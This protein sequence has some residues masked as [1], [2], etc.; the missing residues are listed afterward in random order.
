MLNRIAALPGL[1]VLLHATAFAQSLTSISGTVT[2]LSGAVVPGAK[3]QLT[4]KT[5]NA[6]RETV[7][8]EAG[9]YQ[10]LQIAPG[11]YHLVAKREGFADIS[12][13]DLRLLVNTPATL[14]LSF[15]KVGSLNQVIEISATAVQLNT[16]D[17][18]LGNSFGTKPIVQL[19]LEGRRADR[20]LSLQAG[21]SYIG[22]SDAVN[23]GAQNATDRNGVVNGGRSDQS[24][25]TL[26]GVDINN[27]QTRDPFK[28]SLRVTLDSVQEFRVTTTNANADSSRGSGAQVVM[29]T[30]SG[31]NQFHGAAYEYL[32]NKAANANTFF[33]NAA[34]L[35]TPKLNRNIFGGRLGGKIVKDKL[36]F[37]ANYEGQRDRLEESVTRT[38]PR[39]S[40]RNGQVSYLNAESPG[41][42]VTLTQQQLLG[43]LPDA[44]QINQAALGVLQSYPQPNDFSLGDGFNTAGFRFNSPLARNYDTYV[45]K[46]DYVHSTN[47]RF[48]VR[49]QLQNDVENGAPQFPGRAPNFKDIDKSRGLAIG[50]DATLRSNLLSSTRYGYTRQIVVTEGIGTYAY[51]TF[52]GLS[53]PVGGTLPFIRKS[54]TQHLSQDFTW[55]K[56]NH[57]F[58]FGGSYREYL[59]DRVSFANSFFGMNINSS[60]MTGSGSILSA[61][62]A[63][64]ALPAAQRIAAGSRTAFN[65]GVAS[66]LGL[67]TQVNSRYNYLPHADGSVRAQAIGEGVPRKFKGEESEIYFQDTWRLTRNLTLTGGVRY[68]YWP[69]VYEANGVQTSPNIPLSEFFDRRVAAAEA[70]RSGLEA[71]GF[72]SF[73]L[74][75]RGGRPLYDNLHNWSPRMSLAYS[76]D[77]ANGLSRLLFGG[78]GKSVVRVGWG[79]YYDVFG[80]GLVRASDASALG[81]STNLPNSSGRLTLAETPRFTG[82][83]NV[84][85]QLV[86]PAPAASFPVEQPR[87]AFQIT[88]GLDDRLKAPYIM[89]WNVSATREVKEGLT[90][91]GAYVA[92]EGRRT[93]TSEDMATPLNIRDPQSGTTYFEAAQ[94]LTRLVASNTPT[95]QVPRIA[96]WENLFPGAAGGGLSAT[97]QVFNTFR[98]NYPDATAALESMDRFQDPSVSRL[99]RFA[100]YHPQ[101]SYLRALRSVGFSSYHSMQWTVRKQWRS[102]DQMD[103]NWTWSHSFD[104][105]SVTE[106][107]A[108]TTDGLRGVSINPYNRKQMRAESDFDQR[109]ALN[110]NGIYGLPFG[111]GRAIANSA[112]GLVQQLVGGWQFGGI[113]RWSTGLPIS[114]GHNRTWPT[115]YN[116]TG[117]ATTNGT[118]ADGTNKNGASPVGTANSGPNVFQNPVAARSAFGFTLPGEIG[119]R[120][121]VRGDGLFNID[122][123][124]NKKFDLP[125][126]G[127]GI[128]FRWEVFNVTNSVRFDVRGANINLGQPGAFGRYST[129][130]VPS[131]VMQFGLRYDF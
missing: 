63:A 21:I 49:G 107:N 80:A 125:W 130:L 102:G 8:D 95:A 23:G 31:T 27:Q 16:V 15:E 120:N 40:L 72:I 103:F 13:Q 65:D 56:G 44:R 12:V 127:H 97:Q 86:T 118:F 66:V 9:R 67:V 74:A 76:P 83:F 45:A 126:E 117:W 111:K 109:H 5:T 105:G 52:R 68:M 25:I 51:T 53:D 73:N 116:I 98:D 34:G 71:V 115:N 41:R 93:L 112:S 82:I 58:Q 55:L 3:I 77:G 59:N 92:S 57:T 128:Q 108:S 131:R 2:D 33:N 101:Y 90:I 96:Y 10:A 37:F 99:G 48:F 32:R 35:K 110:L 50:W 100:Y 123:S 88:N 78:K 17:A 30:R 104:L 19:P 39:D 20:L 89:R 61:P 6:V 70:G 36:F 114:V 43:L 4:E 60:W 29:L 22:D 81:L 42:V 11:L 46:I 69:A 113:Y 18:T 121:N 75:S 94:Q 54:P 79:M 106:N 62:L 47:H 84:P 119:N 87:N 28:G 124:L 14:N 122:M 26:D 64:A 85:Q 7:S 129:T 24:N 91:T 1:L 38:V